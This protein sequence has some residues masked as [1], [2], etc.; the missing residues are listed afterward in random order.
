MVLTEKGIKMENSELEKC[1]VERKNEVKKKLVKRYFLISGGLALTIGWMAWKVPVGMSV[2]SDNKFATVIAVLLVGLLLP[3][4][5]DINILLIPND[6]KEAFFIENKAAF[7]HEEVDI[8]EFEVI[9]METKPKSFKCLLKNNQG[10]LNRVVIPFSG[11]KLEGQIGK[12][13][14]AVRHAAVLRELP[15]I[16]EF[17]YTIM[18]MA[19]DTDT[20]QWYLS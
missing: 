1:W 16:E 5:F 7:Y 2:L 20:I 12:V 9:E 19:N 11:V 6:V 13:K 4:L 18:M 10:E 3:F 14:T 17:N 8:Q 15:M